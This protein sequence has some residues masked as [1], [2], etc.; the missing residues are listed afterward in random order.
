MPIIATTMTASALRHLLRPH[1]AAACLLLCALVLWPRAASAQSCWVNGAAELDFGTV[2]ASANTDAQATVNYRCQSGLLGMNVRV[3][4]FVG[5]GNPSGLSP[6]RMTNNNGAFMNY[7]LYS[8]A[9]RTQLLGPVGSLPV[10]SVALTVPGNY[11]GISGTLPIYGRVPAGQNLP[12]AFPYQGFPANS[13]LRYSYGYVFMPS[14]SECRNASPGFLGGAGEVPFSWVGV[15]ASYANTCRITMATD[16][17]F[18]NASALTGNRDHT[19][20]IQLQCPTGTAWRLGLDNGQNASGNNRRMARA[21][22]GLIG[23]E[24]YRDSGRTQRWGNASP[25]DV[26]G[27]G[28]NAVQSQTV[29]G[30]VPAQPVTQ[31]GSYTDTITV[32]LT[33]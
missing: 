24:L 13:V 18:G 25:N 19:S 3:C 16:L 6:R 1:A 9:A 11:Q 14:E 28:N 7:N 31:P 10:Y 23:Y 4:I 22:G 33:Y 12:A 21:G 2:T 20:I 27:T 15:R 26:T 32:T 17:D 5:E 8:N 29:Y 30:R